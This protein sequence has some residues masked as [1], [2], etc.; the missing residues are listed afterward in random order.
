MYNDHRQADINY[1]QQFAY[2]CHQ[3]LVKS[4]LTPLNQQFRL[5]FGKF[6]VLSRGGLLLDVFNKFRKRSLRTPK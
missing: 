4:P 6:V 1:P 3:S 2:F 5:N